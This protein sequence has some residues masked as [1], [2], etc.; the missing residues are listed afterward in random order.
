M[1]ATLRLGELHI[2]VVRKDIRNV[3]LSVHPPNGRTRIAVPR[4][5]SDA[6]IRAFAI[7]KLGWIRAQQQKLQEQ[8]RETPREY[9]DRESHFVWGRRC[10]LRVVEHEAPPVVEWRQH[11]LTLSVRPKTPRER[12]AEILEAWYRVQL[13]AAAEPLVELSQKRLEVRLTSIFV[14][15][16]ENPLGKLQPYSW[17]H[18]AQHRLGQE[19]RRLRR[20]HHRARVGAPDRADPQRPIRGRGGS[21]PSRMGSPPGTAQSPARAAR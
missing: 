21:V 5:L 13:R 2:H 1:Q 20:I 12:R 10:L 14:A 17:H 3:H 4:H 15:A 8:E 18:S 9:L 7:G 6:A 16:H 11:R 19:A